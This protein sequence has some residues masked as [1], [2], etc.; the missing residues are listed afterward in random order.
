MVVAYAFSWWKEHSW[1]NQGDGKRDITSLDAESTLYW[2]E[3]FHR[4]HKRRYEDFVYDNPESI[5]VPIL[6]VN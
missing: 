5:S 3:V 6:C 2:C 1:N 4:V